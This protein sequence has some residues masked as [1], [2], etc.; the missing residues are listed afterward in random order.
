MKNTFTAVLPLHDDVRAELLRRFPPV[1]SRVFA[2]HITYQYG[3]DRNYPWS[4]RPLPVEFYGLVTGPT[5]QT[6][7]CTVAGEPLQPSGKPFHVTISTDD[8]T[9]PSMAS[10]FDPDAIEWIPVWTKQLPLIVKPK[11]LASWESRSIWMH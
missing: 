7:L 11:G 5:T 3:V 6:L 9:P 1:H 2:H 4:P 8:D 10:R